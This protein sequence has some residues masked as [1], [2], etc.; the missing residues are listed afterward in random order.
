MEPTRTLP[1]IDE[2]LFRVRLMAELRRM[3]QEM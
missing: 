3:Q 1:L 2:E